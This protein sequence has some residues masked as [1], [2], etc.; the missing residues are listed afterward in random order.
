MP[1]TNTISPNTRWA[2]YI[3]GGYKNVAP[4]DVRRTAV[5]ELDLVLCDQYEMGFRSE[6]EALK[7]LDNM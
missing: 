7:A 4:Y 3:I 2:A 1:N 5:A 6:K